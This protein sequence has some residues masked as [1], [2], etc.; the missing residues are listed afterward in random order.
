MEIKIPGVTGSH[1]HNALEHVALEQK[2]DSELVR[3]SV[4]MDAL[5]MLSKRAHA[6]KV[7]V[8]PGPI[9]MTGL[10]A[11]KNVTVEFNQEHANV[12]MGKKV[13][14]QGLQ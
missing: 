11:L 4:S 7:H 8:Q 6:M 12:K 1:I 5:V 9:G 3:A 2:Q 13:I 10:S 14:V